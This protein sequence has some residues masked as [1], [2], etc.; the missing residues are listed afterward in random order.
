MMYTSILATDQQGTWIN[1]LPELEHVITEGVDKAASIF[2]VRH[3]NTIEVPALH[4]CYDFT[5][6][7]NRTFSGYDGELKGLESIVRVNGTNVTWINENRRDL[8][9]FVRLTQ[10]KIAYHYYNQTNYD[11]YKAGEM[12]VIPE[13]NLIQINCS[14]VRETRSGVES[15]A[16]VENVSLV[17]VDKILIRLVSSD[18]YT[19]CSAKCSWMPPISVKELMPSLLATIRPTFEKNIKDGV[20]QGLQEMGFSKFYRVY[21]SKNNTDQGSYRI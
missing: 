7:V 5:E 17:S 9:F 2:R 13:T 14:A 12:I 8:S 20:D 19:R 6:S 18:R 15:Y 3:L 21:F 11:F 1:K 10:M 4:H 16:R